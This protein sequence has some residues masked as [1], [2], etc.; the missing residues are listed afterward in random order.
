MKSFTQLSGTTTQGAYPGSFADLSQNNTSV[1]VN[2]GKTLVNTQHR[3][4]LQKYFDNE[5]TYTTV[6]IG[7]Q[8]LTVTASP[9]VGD[10]TATLSVAWV[11]TTC[12]QLVVFPSGEQRTV[13][14]TQGS[15]TISW[16]S[17]LVGKRWC[18]GYS[19]TKFIY[20]FL[21]WLYKDSHVY[22]RFHDDYL[23]WWSGTRCR[24][25]RPHGSNWDKYLC[26]RCA[27]LSYPSEH[28]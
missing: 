23:G 6:T 22:T 27:I 28:L 11:P 9:A 8:K 1:N 16:L 14:F 25:V 24:F 19:Y 10:I 3:Y 7:A 21:R 18:M 15:A 13:F 26:S 2:L 5:R 20:F 17:P 12:Q 4:Y